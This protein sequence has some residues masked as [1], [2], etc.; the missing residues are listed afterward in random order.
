MKDNYPTR[1]SNIGSFIERL[2]PTSHNL[3]SM[4][5]E[6]IDFYNKNGYIKLERIFNK[7]DIKNAF[8]DS[9]LVYNKEKECFLNIEPNDERVRSALS[10]HNID[11]FKSLY[12]NQFLLNVINGIL[13][14]DSYLHQSRINYKAG[15]GTNG[16]N[17]HSD[18]ETWHAKDGMPNIRCVTLM[19]PLV[20]NTNENGALIVLPESHKLFWSAPKM[21]DFNPEDEFAEQKEGVPT[22]EVI[23]HYKNKYGTEEKTILCDVGDAV[24][25]DCNLLHVSKGNTTP[26]KRTN[27]FFVFNSIENKLVN[28]FDG[29]DPRPEEMGAR[30]NITI[31]NKKHETCKV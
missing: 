22:N 30:K 12:K 4:N 24:I 21:G 18:F 10:I 5:D 8:N 26:D 23:S 19:I 16:W 28:P 17:W 14:S 29:S 31:I 11:S 1:K 27:A 3:K 20:R 2:S 25:F 9:E 6:N 13:G 15:L 7:L